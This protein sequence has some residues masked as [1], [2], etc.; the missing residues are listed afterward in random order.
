MKKIGLN[1]D[2]LFIR[3]VAEHGATSGELVTEVF[4]RIFFKL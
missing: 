3:G 2:S 4:V 1:A